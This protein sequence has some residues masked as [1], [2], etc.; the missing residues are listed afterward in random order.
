MRH[1][2]PIAGAGFQD[3]DIATMNIEAMKGTL[4]F[5]DSILIVSCW[6]DITLG[7]ILLLQALGLWFLRND[8]E[9][10]NRY[11][12]EGRRC[13]KIGLILVVIGVIGLLSIPWFFRAVTGEL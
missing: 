6:I 1:K 2:I 7:A 8:L 12:G 5:V 9:T 11:K 4:H 13:L 10:Q 3:L